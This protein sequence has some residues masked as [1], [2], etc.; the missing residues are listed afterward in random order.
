MAKYQIKGPDGSTF[1]INAPDDA[2]QDQVMA[3]AQQNFK[4]GQAAPKPKGDAAG[5]GKVQGVLM[6]LNDMPIAAGQA[7]QNIPGVGGALNLLRGGIKA[8]LS[9]VGAT[10]AAELFNDVSPQE[11]NQR[12]KSREQQYE[13]DRAA[14]GREGFDFARLGGNV[15]NPVNLLGA[16]TMKGAST[17]ANLAKYGAKAGAVGGAMQPVVNGGEGYWADKAGQVAAGAATGAVLTPAVSKAATGMAKTAGALK[18]RVMP[19]AQTVGVD[20]KVTVNNAF[21]AAGINPAD[22]PEAVMQSVQRQAQEALDAG[23]KIDPASMLRKAQF[24]AV[25]LTGDAAPTLGQATRDPMQFANEKNISGVR[26]KTAQGEGNPLSDRFQLQN[27]RLGEVF[28]QVGATNATDRVTAG[29]SIMDALR[30]TD[31]PVKSAVD[32]AYTSARAMTGGRAADLERETFSRTANETLDQGMWGRFV[33]TEIRGLLNDVSEGKTP[34]NVDSAVQIDSIL[35]GAQRKAQRAG[36]D[37]GSSAIGV[38][39]DALHNTPLAKTSPSFGSQPPSAAADAARTMQNGVDDVAF[40][41]VGK[42]GVPAVIEPAGSG[43][44]M[45]NSARVPPAGA[46]PVD[47]GAAA[48]QAFDEA[49][50]AARSRFATIEQTPALKAALDEAAP[51]KFVQQYIQNANVADLKAMKKVLENSPEALGQA[52]AQLADHLKRAAFGENPS[53]DKAFAAD[54]YLNTLRGLGKQKLDVFFTEAE[55]VRMNLA[56]KVASDINSI[57]VGAKFGTNTSGTGASVMNLLNKLSESPLMRQLPA[58]RMVANHIGEIQTER[59]INRALTPPLPE[60][61]ANELS[62]ETLRVIKL[63][64]PLAGAAGGAL[65]GAA[66]N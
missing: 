60:K 51:D 18:D 46:A 30:K 13:A 50:K 44:T 37:A 49:R 35:S 39:R 48:R 52:R 16:G 14:A 10:D 53:G 63:M 58:A 9:G 45:P 2:T 66:A 11:F 43:F 64:F 17:V 36:D 34:F 38:I 5:G 3:Y 6:G 29:Q 8:G 59:S 22:V 42:T 62:P 41:E 23:A 31:A 65:G 32:D 15:A 33:P 24:E 4:G 47:E 57:P 1:E 55:I 21:S 19:A 7:L 28:D 56:G 26:I 12:V 20:V 61:A 27:Q 54:R 40:R 25:G